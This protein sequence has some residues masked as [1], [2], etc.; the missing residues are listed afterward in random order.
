MTVP[1]VAPGP[2]AW[3]A[4]RPAIVA[5]A[6]AGARLAVGPL[7]LG[8]ALRLV[9]FHSASQLLSLVPGAAGLL[10]R[11]AWYEATLEAC[12]QRLRVQFG[13]VLRDQRTRLG[14][15]CHIGEYSCIGLADIGASFLGGDHVSV[16]GGRHAH[17]FD[18]R[19][20][21]MSEQPG[22]TV[23]VVIGEDVWAGA[24]ARIA[25]DVAAHS[26]VGAGAVVV[27]RFGE[28]QVLGGVPARVIA[29]RPAG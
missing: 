18:R 19:D 26:I 29:E 11:R 22:E 9:S 3:D 14:D 13:A 20:L 21:P 8:R 24:G 12:G 17:R 10:V 23:R 16:V 28:W 4:E 27:E 1:P 7:L 5:A 6:T 15:D 25:A 2:R